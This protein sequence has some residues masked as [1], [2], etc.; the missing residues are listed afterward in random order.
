MKKRTDE[1]VKAAIAEST[2]IRQVLVKLGLSPQGGG[3]YKQLHDFIRAHAVDT[4]HFS[5]QCWNKGKEFTKRDINVYLSN[6]K[7]I[8]SHKLR[9]RLLGEKIFPYACSACSLVEWQGQPIPL[10]LDHINGNHYDNSLS[11]L[12]LLCPNCHS[13]TP[14]HTGRN[15]GKAKYQP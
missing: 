13:L 14:T 6:E 10:E 1:E 8:H 11:N 3:S 15:R 12:R 4:S 2:S 9:I 7:P 5:G